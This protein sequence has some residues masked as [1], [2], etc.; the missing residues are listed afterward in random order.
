LVLGPGNATELRWQTDPARNGRMVITG[1][2]CH[3]QTREYR[4]LS[5]YSDN[6]GVTWNRGVES[7]RG[8]WNENQIVELTNGDLLR[9]GRSEQAPYRYRWISHDG[10]V[11]WGS[12]YASDI[13]VSAVD[14]GL[15]RYSARRNGQDRDRILISAPL[16]DPPGSGNDRWNIGVWTSYD[17]GKTFI[18]PIQ[19][20]PTDQ[21]FGAY[22]GMQKLPDGSIAMIYEQ[23]WRTWI[24]LAKFKMADV[25]GHAFSSH[26]GEYDG[27]GNNIDR[28]RGGIG[29]AG[30][31]T[32]A[33]VATNAYSAQLGGM[34]LGFAGSSFPT[35]DGRMDLTTGQNTA[36]RQLATPIDLNNNGATYVAVLVSQVLDTASNLDGRPLTIDLLDSSEVS[37]ASFGVGAQEN[38]YISNLG[39]VHS[40]ASGFVDGDATYLLLLKIV[41]QDSAA[42]NHDQIFLKVFQSGVDTIPLTD[43]GLNWTLAGSTDANI[44]AL[45]DR[46]AFRSGSEATWTFDELRIGDTFGSV[47]HAPEPSAVCLVGIGALCLM[48]HVWKKRRQ[49]MI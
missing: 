19:I 25:E 32:G 15:T 26:L 7:D 20:G 48:A 41:S 36:K 34:G 28:N 23:T 33:G 14:C 24:R 2:N 11:T 37:W 43:V 17:E 9:D 46:I 18:N 16:G 3:T 44:S 21:P 35:Q 29:W 12:P 4:V 10:G 5:A 42:G 38:F 40:T 22:S 39:G 47:A 13:P 30:S 49:F 1:Y 45:L 8:A 27:F 31:W 6:H